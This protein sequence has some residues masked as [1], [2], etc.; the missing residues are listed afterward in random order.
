M[1]RLQSRSLTLNQFNFEWWNR[2]KLLIKKKN[3]QK[4]KKIRIKFERE[5]P[6]EDEIWKK[7]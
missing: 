6:N 5:K 4:H 1:T 3:L 7:K 2:W